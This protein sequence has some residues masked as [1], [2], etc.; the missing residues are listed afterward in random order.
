MNWFLNPFSCFLS[1]CCFDSWQEQSY[2]L[3]C[4]RES[5]LS[6]IRSQEW[7]TSLLCNMLC[8]KKLEKC[9]F[10]KYTNLSCNYFQREIYELSGNSHV[11]IFIFHVLVGFS[12]RSIQEKKSDRWTWAAC[13]SGIR[14]CHTRLSSV[15]MHVSC[16]LLSTKLVIRTEKP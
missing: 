14:V 8:L 15:F 3:F 4:S 10:H 9:S 1:D 12:L 2:A 16:V 6:V 13:A 7:N 11:Y 5:L